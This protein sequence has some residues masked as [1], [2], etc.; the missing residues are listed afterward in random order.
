MRRVLTFTRLKFKDFH[1]DENPR[2]PIDVIVG[3]KTG[4]LVVWRLS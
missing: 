2:R 1:P 3:D 4:F